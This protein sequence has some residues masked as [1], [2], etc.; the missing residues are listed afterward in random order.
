MGRLRVTALACVAFTITT[1]AAAQDPGVP[2]EPP[3]SPLVGPVRPSVLASPVLPSPFELALA[4]GGRR[5][6]VPD[7]FGDLLRA[8]RNIT[9]PYNLAG[10]V[11]GT[12][13]NGT[14]LLRNT[15]VAEN[16]T[17]V[18]RDRV[19]VRYH[20]FHNGSSVTGV[21]PFG[22]PTRRVIAP[23]DIGLQGLPPGVTLPPSAQLV[24]PN[25]LLGQFQF[26]LANDRLDELN[27]AFPPDGTGVIFDPGS[28][29]QGSRVSPSFFQNDPNSTLF[30]LERLVLNRNVRPAARD[31]DV[32]LVNLS[33]EKTLFDGEASVEFRLPFVRAV[34]SDLSLVSSSEIDDPFTR[35]QLVAPSGDTLG[36]TGTEIKDVQIVLKGIV[37]SFED[38]T[39]SSGLGVSAPTAEDVNVTIVDGFPDPTFRVRAFGVD[40]LADVLRTREVTVR[41]ETVALSPFVAVT[42]TPTQRVF[43]NGFL[44]F[45]FPV[46]QDRVTVRE[47]DQARFV[48]IA[49]QPRQPFTV[50]TESEGRIQDQTLMHLDVGGG[51]WL[52]RNPRGNGVTGVAAMAELHWTSTLQDA[53]VFENRSSFLGTPVL[54]PRR[55]LDGTAEPVVEEPALQVGNTGNRTDIVNVTIGGT[56]LIDERISFG[57]ATSLPLNDKVFDVEIQARLNVLLGPRVQ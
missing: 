1:M 12:T 26:T 36:D 23:L 19:G 49:G 25:P 33:F 8:N 2:P 18:P 40:P 5:S 14:I 11:A 56:L 39:V 51:Y 47:T 37:A 7:M 45:D 22:P 28:T 35:S 44:Q 24:A 31:Y 32:Q 30:N 57:L 10:D 16:N 43:L 34:N 6:G 9:F 3:R 17:A 38:W 46:G 27:T 29:T 55:R 21:E 42:G 52:H 20:W 54:L 15:K 48:I 41:N 4:R 53:D 13:A 50:V